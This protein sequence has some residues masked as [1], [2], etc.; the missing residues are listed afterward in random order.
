MTCKAWQT[1][2]VIKVLYSGFMYA[3]SSFRV[4]QVPFASLFVRSRLRVKGRNCEE[5]T[6]RPHTAVHAYLHSERE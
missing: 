6:N 2:S 3:F 4:P 5:G 1:R